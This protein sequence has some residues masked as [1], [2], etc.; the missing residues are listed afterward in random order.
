MSPAT[1]TKNEEPR[2]TCESTT[3][4]WK[5]G[6]I[7]FHVVEPSGLEYL[8]RVSAKGKIR[9]HML[10]AGQPQMASLLHISAGELVHCMARRLKPGFKFRWGQVG[11]SCRVVIEY[12]CQ[13]PEE[14]GATLLLQ[15]WLTGKL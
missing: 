11:R 15:E 9:T 1:E 10:S 3:I 8:V 6:W 13:H 14:Q 4:I 12:F 7:A 5:A 2:P